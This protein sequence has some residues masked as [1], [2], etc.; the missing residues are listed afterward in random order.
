MSLSVCEAVSH[1]I[2]RESY[3]NSNC[4]HS[5]CHVHPLAYDSA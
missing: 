1:R 3:W 5:D 2:L 4:R